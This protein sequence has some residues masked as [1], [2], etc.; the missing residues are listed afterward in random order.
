MMN[1]SKHIMAALDHITAAAKHDGRHPCEIDHSGLQGNPLV[2]QDAGG[3]MLF[4]K[5][6]QIVN[7][8]REK[9]F[10]DKTRMQ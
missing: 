9:H 4:Y 5:L 8:E 6:E 7:E 3:Q 10:T 2:E 1:A